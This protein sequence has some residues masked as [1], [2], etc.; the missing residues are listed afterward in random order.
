MLNMYNKI[1]GVPESLEIIKWIKRNWLRIIIAIVIILIGLT[2][3]IRM[4]KNS[5]DKTVDILDENF[6]TIDQ[7]ASDL[8]EG[9]F[10]GMNEFL[11]RNF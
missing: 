10:E 11:D 2:L 3:V 5:L 4:I 7:K 9:R 8:L 1:P 6:S